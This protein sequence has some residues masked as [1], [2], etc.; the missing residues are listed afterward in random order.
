MGKVVII[1]GGISGLSIAQLLKNKHQ[2]IVFEADS[3]PGGMI[4]CDI[5]N[6]SLFHRT[7]GHVFNTKRQDVFDW[8]WSFFDKDKEF[9]K[10]LRNASVF[11]PDGKIIPYPIENHVYLLGEPI[12]KDFITDM[13]SIA[14]TNTH[15]STNFG[16][17]L[18]DQF[19]KT[20]YEIYFQ[21]YNY[22]VWRR[23]LN[24]ISLSWLE[25]KLPMPTVEE[26]IYNNINRVEE[27]SFVH[28]SF[29]YPIKGGSQFIANRL[30]CGLNI[31]YNTL[32]KKIVKTENKW[33]VN[34]VDADVVIFCGN[35]KQFPEIISDQIEINSYVRTIE[36]LESHGTTS[37]FCEIQQNP[38]S[39]IYL[40]SQEH[41]SHRIICTGNFSSSNNSIGKMTATIEFTDYISKEN[42]LDNLKCIPFVTKY[43]THHYEQYT[44]PI[45]NTTTREMFTS[46]K[47]I[48]TRENIYLLGRFAEW[49]YYNM[50]AAIG[51]ALELNNNL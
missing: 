49:E 41:E 35:I 46:L 13:I 40:P 42:I 18:C 44:Y 14:K 47:S 48:L 15:I 32:I 4:K 16:D 39:W 30:A 6:R 29:F 9:A 51:A 11:M 45:Q 5:V 37:V 17:F 50:D 24:K 26:M 10:I 34:G 22:K 23:D 28:S 12:I 7:G 3:R 2:I 38:Y 33:F 27:H 19:G 25:G 21:P 43:L 36:Q 31:I 1:G 8:F 20:L